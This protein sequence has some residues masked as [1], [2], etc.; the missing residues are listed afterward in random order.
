MNDKYAS[1][2]SLI[3]RIL[4]ALMFIPAGFGKLANIAGTA[5][6]FAGKGLPFPLAVAVLVGALE[7]LGGLA[8]II[9]FKARWTGLALGLFTLAASWVGHAFW[10]MPEAQQMVHQT[11]FMKNMSVAGGML[12]VSALGAGA[13][14]VDAMRGQ[15]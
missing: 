11:M 10:A 7:L 4:L 5:A 9:G 2:V 8:L 1:T 15:R 6:G 3:G 13:F 12:L 14:S